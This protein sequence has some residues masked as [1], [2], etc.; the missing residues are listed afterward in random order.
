MWRTSSGSF[1]ESK[2]SAS[3]V[4]TSDF[5]QLFQKDLDI[6]SQPKL[7]SINVGKQLSVL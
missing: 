4:L 1:S 7:I 5:V 6:D 3:I 2:N